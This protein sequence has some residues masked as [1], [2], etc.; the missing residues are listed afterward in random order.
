MIRV[1]GVKDGSACNN[2]TAVC[3]SEAIS[4][5]SGWDDIP[6]DSCITMFVCHSQRAASFVSN[7][8]LPIIVDRACASWQ[9][10]VQAAERPVQPKR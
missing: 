1:A 4:G 9:Q 5:W 8:G 3:I 7:C 10:E 6:A 2:F